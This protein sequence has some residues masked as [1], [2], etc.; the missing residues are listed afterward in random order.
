[1]K[2]GMSPLLATVLLIAFAVSL[3]ALV[4]SVG[5]QMHDQGSLDLNAT[6]VCSHVDFRIHEVDGKKS[7]CY[8]PDASVIRFVG[9]NRG[10]KSIPSMQIWVVGKELYRADVLEDPLKPLVP[11]ERQIAYDSSTY[12]TIRRIQFIPSVHIEELQDPYICLDYPSEI[13]EIRYC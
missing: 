1:M 5:R 3:G 12:G 7:I 4:M 13:Q 2:K 10:V 11:I 8:D 9:V 6:E